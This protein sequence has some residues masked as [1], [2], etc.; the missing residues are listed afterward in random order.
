MTEADIVNA[1]F[2]PFHYFVYLGT[3]MVLL[4][5]FLQWKWSRVAKNN[6]LLLI[7]QQGGGGEYI[8]SPKSGGE[9]TIKNA[10][11]GIVRMWPIN[12][13]TT[14]EVPYPGTG[15]VPGFLQKSIRMAIVSEDDWEP[16]LN[17]SPHRSKVMSP[18]VITTL[19][20]IASSSTNT[21][22]KKAINDLLEGVATAPTRAMI[23][24]PAVLGNLIE[25][26]ISQLAVTVAKDVI[27]PLNEAMKKIGKNI[28][29]TYVYIGLGLIII[30][31]S[32]MIISIPPAMSELE[33]SINQI[34]DS[35]GILGGS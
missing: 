4:I 10:K 31:L 5:V 3:L 7:T 32:Y 35:L 22:T 17:R 28:N 16:L 34:K 26:K 29:A 33:S 13:L 2:S 24:S 18:D 27:N 14:I 12:E 25:E 9:V 19:L 8:L 21:S 23:A 30:L 11:T 15:F 1:W 20:T 6:I